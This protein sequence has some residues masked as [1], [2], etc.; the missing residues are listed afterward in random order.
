ME[1]SSAT[2]SLRTDQAGLIVSGCFSPSGTLLVVASAEPTSAPDVLFAKVGPSDQG[3]EVPNDIGPGGSF[4][5]G[6]L[7]GEVEAEVGAVESAQS[8]EDTPLAVYRN[9][10]APERAHK[11]FRPRRRAHRGRCR[12]GAAPTSSAQFAILSY[13]DGLVA[14]PLRFDGRCPTIQVGEYLEADGEK[15]HEQLFIDPHVESSPVRYTPALTHA[16]PNIHV[17]LSSSQR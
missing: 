16:F 10:A 8:P 11:S 2:F 9:R 3:I 15:E 12:P 4:V 14:V 7:D 17:A 13:R 5:A 6:V 1:T